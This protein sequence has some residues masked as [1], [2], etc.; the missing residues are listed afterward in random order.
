MVNYLVVSFTAEETFSS[1]LAV[2]AR[3]KRAENLYRD[4]GAKSY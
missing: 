1:N 3:Y 4:G 2:G